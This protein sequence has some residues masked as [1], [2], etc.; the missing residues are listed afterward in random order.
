MKLV[1]LP[2]RT[3]QFDRTNPR[4]ADSEFYRLL[5]LSIRKL[6]LLSPIY[7][8]QFGKILSGH[9]RTTILKNLGHREVPAII[10]E[11]REGSERTAGVNVLFNR[12]LQEFHTVE[13]DYR[14][15]REEAVRVL[16][17]L[18]FQEDAFAPL[19]NMRAATEHEI[20]Q[21]AQTQEA[22]AGKHLHAQV[23]YRKI[24]VMI[25]VISSGGEIVNGVVRAASYVAMCG[26]F[27]VIEAPASCGVVFKAITAVY[28]MEKMRDVLRVSARRSFFTIKPLAALNSFISREVLIS[29]NALKW[30]YRQ[31]FERIL[32]FGCG[33]AQQSAPLRQMGV[34]IT[35]FEPFVI[36]R[37][38]KFGFVQTRKIIESFLDDLEQNGLFDLVYSNAVFNSI[39][40]EG[41]RCKVAVLLKFLSTG[42]KMFVMGTRKTLGKSV[43]Q[44]QNKTGIGA[45]RNLVKLQASFTKEQLHEYFDHKG[46]VSYYS[47][48]IIYLVQ[49][50]KW[51][52]EKS[53]LLDAVRMEFGFRYY[54]R[55]FVSLQN[56]AL[57]IFSEL[58][59]R[60]YGEAHE[61]E[62]TE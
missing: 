61:G 28:N 19:Q 51:Q 11:M 18:P 45:T 58:Y 6:G 38:G 12:V 4:E 44:S 10:V 17:S 57:A 32:D 49:K 9:Q 27:P 33:N 30:F 29:T 56:R 24:G 53:A 52:I 31:N 25:P 34:H 41:D 3:L 36:N 14:A 47:N 13:E 1:S 20:A 16:E 46:H 50:P 26:T 5:E 54:D 60:H 43:F 39:P 8:D 35:L 48:T 42:A 55:Q 37:S 23:L 62:H 2:I 7:V 40:F 22:K 59:D 15:L 21:V